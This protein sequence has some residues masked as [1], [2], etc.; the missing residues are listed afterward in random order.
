M[1]AIKVVLLEDEQAQVTPEKVYMGEHRAARLEISLP[2]RLRG[3][4]DYYNLCFDVMG[5]GKRIPLGNIYEAGTGGDEPE[6]LAWMEDGEII[7]DLPESLTQC[8]YLRA[9]VEAYC[10]EGGLCTR[11]EKSAPF[12]IAFED[13]IAGEGDALSALALGH[14]TKLMAQLNRLRRTLRVQVQGAQEVIEPAVA[15]AEQAAGRAEQ[16]AAD[17]LALGITPGPQGAK[18]DKGEKGDKGDTG[19]Q[20]EAGIGIAYKDTV[21]AYTDLPAQAQFG[22]AY[23]ALEDGLLYIYGAGGFPAQGEGAL[24]KG[25]AG[26]QGPKGD[27]GATGLQGP[28]GDKGDTGATGPQG[29]KGDA[30]ATGPQ[31]PAGS[32]GGGVYGGR[33]NT[34]MITHTAAG[35]VVITAALDGLR[36]G[37]GVTY[38]GDSIVIEQAGDYL[39]GYS[40]G[41]VLTGS[42]FVN[43]HL[44]VNGETV[45]GLGRGINGTINQ[46]MSATGILHL[47]QGDA[48]TLALS[49]G[50]ATTFYVYPFYAELSV[51]K[52]G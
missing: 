38:S 49:V 1:R 34:Q 31:G 21:A 33:H 41:V 23:V 19:E 12:V 4:F 13:S 9:Q 15:R 24:F 42:A 30:G 17:V 20:G 50:L 10:E 22:D 51:V 2:E 26:S 47:Q 52:I 5:A 32:A 46:V 44:Q 45:D 3:G 35:G 7:C 11:L 16:A 18:G 36:S 37:S 43:T 8:S 29:P 6:G 48:V 25:P 28:K 40:T 27:T 14:M 39:V